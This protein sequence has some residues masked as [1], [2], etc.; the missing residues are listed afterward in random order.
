[1]IG[2]SLVNEDLISPLA[3]PQELCAEIPPLA[4]LWRSWISAKKA[5]DHF[6][7]MSKALEETQPADDSVGWLS[8][9]FAMHYLSELARRPGCEKYRDYILANARTAWTS[10]RLSD[11]LNGF[12]WA[13]SPSSE[14]EVDP[15]HAISAAFLYF[16]AS[17]ACR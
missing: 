8:R 2:I 4:P 5:A 6:M 15:K 11:G 9:G 7:K 13:K 12:D 3:S 10:R 14:E 1:M 17:R 16:S